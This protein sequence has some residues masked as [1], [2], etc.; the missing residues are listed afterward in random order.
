MFQACRGSYSYDA[1]N[2]LVGAAVARHDDGDMPDMQINMERTPEKD[3]CLGEAP[4]EAR[5]QA[6]QIKPA[7]S[8]TRN[9]CTTYDDV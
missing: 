1:V 3:P 9:P 7:I 5:S 8:A 2:I 6:I 4:R